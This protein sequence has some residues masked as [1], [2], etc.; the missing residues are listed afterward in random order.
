VA[1]VRSAEERAAQAERR[2]R[3]LA[4]VLC[5]EPRLLSPAEL[6]ALRDG[7]ASG[8]AVLAAALKRLARARSGADPGGLDGALADVA[9]AAI[10]WRDRLI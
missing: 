10:R 8:P 2:V 1:A 9:S 3:E 7:G 5:G 6:A 4:L